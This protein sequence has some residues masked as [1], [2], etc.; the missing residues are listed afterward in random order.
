MT[1]LR[2]RFPPKMELIED[3]FSKFFQSGEVSVM[4]TQMAS[5]FPNPLYGIQVRAVRRREIKTE[6]LLMFP[7]PRLKGFRM[8]PTCVVHDDDHLASLSRMAQELFQERFEREGVKSLLWPCDQAAVSN[9]NCPKNS[10]TFARRSV[11]ENGIEF[12]RR[13]PHVAARHLDLS[14]PFWHSFQEESLQSALIAS[15]SHPHHQPTLPVI[16]HR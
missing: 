6:H 4:S 13:D 3:H 10:D 1:Q 8:V 15:P 11:C 2:V 9:T 7:Q 5:R 14:N 16:H 12:L